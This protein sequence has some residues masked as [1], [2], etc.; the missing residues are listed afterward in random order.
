MTRFGRRLGGCLVAVAVAGLGVVAPVG[1][2]P[3]ACAA[4][5]APHRVAVVVEHGD[6]TFMSACVGFATDAISGIDALASSGMGY[7]TEGFGGFGQAICQLDG[8]PAT[9]PSSCFGTG[10]SYWAVFVAR[11]GTSWSLS[12]LGVSSLRLRDGDAEGFRYDPQSGTAV[13]PDAPGRC[14]GPTPGPTL[15]RPT[16]APATTAPSAK[17]APSTARPATGG[18]AGPTPAASVTPATTTG[19]PTGPPTPPAS[20]PG[21]ATNSPDAAASGGA[22]V[23]G[24]PLLDAG[25]SGTGIGAARDGPSSDAVAVAVAL[26]AFTVLVVAGIALARRRGRP[27]GR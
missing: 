17:V 10:G 9:Y 15:P 2:G 13:A 5:D 27:S 23:A 19:A 18:A 21:A 1:A 4:A 6:G 3:P 7:A 20:D 22:G 8:E 24:A 25:S 26:A 11:N 14:P 16:S 12:S